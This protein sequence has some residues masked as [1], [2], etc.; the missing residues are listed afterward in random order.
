MNPPPASENCHLCNQVLVELRKALESIAGFNKIV[1]G[2]VTQTC[3]E[4]SARISNSFRLRKDAEHAGLAHGSKAANVGS[5]KEGH[6]HGDACNAQ[7]I[8]QS[9]ADGQP[10]SRTADVDDS[11]VVQSMADDDSM[12]ASRC[13]GVHAMDVSQQT[14]A[15]ENGDSSVAHMDSPGQGD[16]RIDR[17]PGSKTGHAAVG[18]PGCKEGPPEPES[19]ARLQQSKAHQE[20]E[21]RLSQAVSRFFV[22]STALEQTKVLFQRPSLRSDLVLLTLPYQP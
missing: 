22:L 7:L 8:A 12:Q 17:S 19:E 1:W 11:N 14:C 6:Q 4:E 21:G 9:T 20:L 15:S 18:L 2:E 13:A 3:Q 5:D 10:S 16:A